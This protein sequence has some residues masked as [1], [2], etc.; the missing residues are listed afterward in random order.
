MKRV[1]SHKETNK[2]V[3]KYIKLLG[4]EITRNKKHACLRHGKHRLTFSCT[5]SDG[6]SYKQIERDI[7][8]IFGALLRAN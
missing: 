8:K 4:L 5:P 6:N 1:S 2:I 3:K 7:L